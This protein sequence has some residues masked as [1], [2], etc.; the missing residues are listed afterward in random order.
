M[1][2]KKL[3]AD[4]MFGNGLQ[5]LFAVVVVQCGAY[6]IQQIVHLSCFRYVP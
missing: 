3:L 5:V 4:R 1:Q 6:V 2:E